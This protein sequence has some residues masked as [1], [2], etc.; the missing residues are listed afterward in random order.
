[1]KLL[2]GTTLHRNKRGLL[3]FTF[4]SPI[5]RNKTTRP[6]V[7][8]AL[9]LTG[10]ISILVV[11]ITALF[12]INSNKT[13]IYGL[14]INEITLH[15]LSYEQ[16]SEILHNQSDRILAKDLTFRAQDTTR[17]TTVAATG[18]QIDVP[19]TLESARQKG[20]T[21]SMWHKIYTQVKSV[22]DNTSH[23]LATSFDEK[24][25]SLYRQ[26]TLKGLF[27]YPQNAEARYEPQGQTF[28][29][30]P[31]I[32]GVAID[33]KT[34]RYD[35]VSRIQNFSTQPIAV[36]RYTA[37]PNEINNLDA[38]KTY[39]LSITPPQLTL[40]LP[41]K[42]PLKVSQNEILK[43]YIFFE[44]A[45]GEPSFRYSPKTIRRYVVRL[46]KLHNQKPRNAR[47]ILERDNPIIL[48]QDING[49]NIL[50]DQSVEAIQQAL[51]KNYISIELPTVII[52]AD[53]HPY[54]IQELGFTLLGIGE[55]YFSG[56]PTNRRHNILLGAE[57]Y[58]GILLKPGEEFSFNDNLGEVSAE[59]GYRP[60]YVILNN[61]TT[62]GY[63]GGLCQV[64][65]TLFRAVVYAGLDVT[66]RQHH[67][68]AVP[69][70]GTP[71]FDATI[72]S[73][74]PD[75]RFKN[76]TEGHILI[77]YKTEGERLVFEIYGKDEGKKTFVQGPYLYDEQP[78]GAVKAYLI[79]RVLQN[80]IVVHEET[81]YSNYG[82]PSDYPIQ[83]NPLL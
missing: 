43:W 79:Q 83:T 15:H 44:K 34:L 1:M 35:I 77:Q 25:F 53:I 72:Y 16:A 71:G 37:V 17:T 67:S 14:S 58:Q 46:T 68:Y 56:S 2:R 11:C 59:T 19:A 18:I 76:T 20:R 75:F 13:F 62:K 65:T 5:Q 54:N 36:H 52:Q 45:P 73:P 81:F 63:G 3:P 21:G 78:G 39:A 38:L 47:F 55:T 6:W 60:D 41:N 28:N 26:E 80:N 48:D 27:Q 23:P 33:E 64:S 4:R 40:I 30:T 57:R 31:S 61:V 49:Y 82:S 22:V 8:V 32:Q 24:Q 42:A 66:A 50:V 9:M 7:K 74:Q 29:I 69:Y 10:C 12:V 70:Y 51:T